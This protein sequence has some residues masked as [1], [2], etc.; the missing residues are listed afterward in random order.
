MLRYLAIFTMLI[1]HIGV[2][3]FPE[4]VVLRIIGRI[5]MPIY[6]YICAEAI[7]Q[8]SN[9]KKYTIRLLLI[10]L[11]AQFPYLMAFNIN[12]LNIVFNLL[13][14]VITIYLLKNQRNFNIAKMSLIIF[15]SIG[16][17]FTIEYSFYCLFLM[18][19]FY[20]I[21]GNKFLLIYHLV[22]NLIVFAL[23]GEAIQMFSI[24]ATLLIIYKD[25]MPDLRINNFFYRSFYPLH[26]TILF[27][28]KLIFY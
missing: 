24:F 5:A 16:V 27:F 13:L 17:S 22:L 19:G 1:D 15:I 2:M 26:L 20:F 18:L 10:A 28:I 25:R 21:K 7:N 6:V 9:F 12:G 14:S 23:Y 8:T 4:Y 3:F 11:L